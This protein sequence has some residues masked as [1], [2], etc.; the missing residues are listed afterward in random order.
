[1]VKHP[2]LVPSIFLVSSKKYEVKHCRDGRRRPS[3]WPILG[4]IFFNFFLKFVQYFAINIRIYLLIGWKGS[5]IESSLPIPSNQKH[6]L[7]LMKAYGVTFGGSWSFSFQIIVANQFIIPSSK[8]VLKI[9]FFL[10]S[11]Q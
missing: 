5:V 1:M 7:L 6:N 9:M 8:W 4:V 10:A 2:S 11:N 3:G